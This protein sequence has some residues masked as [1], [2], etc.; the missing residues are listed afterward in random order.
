MLY[1]QTLVK[2]L[3]FID[4]TISL[5]DNIPSNILEQLNKLE[6]YNK[7]GD[8]VCYYDRWDDLIILAKNAMVAGVLSRKCWENIEK[9]FWYKAELA[10][11]ME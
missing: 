11:Q 6:Y 1:S 9:R 8:S 10:C 7:E 4:Y 3:N 5:Q 2:E